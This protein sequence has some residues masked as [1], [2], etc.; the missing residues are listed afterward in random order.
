[1]SSGQLAVRGRAMDLS[2]LFSPATLGMEGYLWRD[3]RVPG[4]EQHGCHIETWRTATLE[5]GPG[6]PWTL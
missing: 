3:G 6:V 2:S 5:S 4:S 1:M